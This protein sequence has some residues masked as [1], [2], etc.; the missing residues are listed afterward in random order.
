MSG[1]PP[2]DSLKTCPGQVSPHMGQGGELTVGH[3]GVTPKWQGGV[4]DYFGCATL[5]LTAL[6]IGLY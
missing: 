5:V 3:T 2:R 6:A 1:K 4:L